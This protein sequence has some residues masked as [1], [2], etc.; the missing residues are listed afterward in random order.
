MRIA[1]PGNGLDPYL[2]ATD[3]IKDAMKEAIT[4]AENA[5]NV[6]KDHKD[7]QHVSDMLK[8]MFGEGAEYESK[9]EAI[10]SGHKGFFFR[11]HTRD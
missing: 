7:D 4:M 9:F 6:M 10:K 3:P 8:L 2:Q 5:V 1:D 11:S